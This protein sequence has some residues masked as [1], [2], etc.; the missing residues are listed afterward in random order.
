MKW[1]VLCWPSMYE[2]RTLYIWMDVCVFRMDESF[3]WLY[4]RMNL[5]VLCGEHAN[6]P[7][8]HELNSIEL[9]FQCVMLSCPFYSLHSTYLEHKY[10]TESKRKGEDQKKT[11]PETNQ[12]FDLF[13]SLD[14][15]SSSVAVFFTFHFILFIPVQLCT[16]LAFRISW[17]GKCFKCSNYVKA[18]EIYM[19]YTIIQGLFNRKF[20]SRMLEQTIH[21][22][23]M[24]TEMENEWCTVSVLQ[25]K[26]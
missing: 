4:V 10:Y 14:L 18:I 20:L 6:I 26:A 17:R 22:D 11:Q 23:R 15:L 2:H 13:S 1:H 24:D 7:R 19:L 16:H 12:I 3:I 8:F 5:I 25:Y 21:I 9:N